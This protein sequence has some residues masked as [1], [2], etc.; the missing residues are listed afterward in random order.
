M[1]AKFEVCIFSRSRDIRVFRKVKSRSRDPG[2]APL[3]PN[4]VILN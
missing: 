3:W 4:F 1:R 2:R